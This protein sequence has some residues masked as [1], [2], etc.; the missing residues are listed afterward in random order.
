MI[1]GHNV[2]EM[3]HSQHRI[4]DFLDKLSDHRT[5]GGP[6]LAINVA[7][8]GER[9]YGTSYC[10]PAHAKLFRELVVL[11]F[12]NNLRNHKGVRAKVLIVNFYKAQAEYTQRLIAELSPAVVVHDLI[13]VQTIPA[14]QENEGNIVILDF[15]R[16]NDPGFV[17]Q[18]E[19]LNTGATRAIDALIVVQNRSVWRHKK[20]SK[21]D[22]RI[23]YLIELDQHT[24]D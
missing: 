17:G 2:S 11:I 6:I 22:T 9:K 5:C 1:E 24:L 7:G 12:K 18:A 10:N 8:D 13:Q 23:K 14:A 15:V 20:T 19:L 3:E 21:G 4:L 16:G